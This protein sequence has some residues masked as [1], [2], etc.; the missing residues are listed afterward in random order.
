MVLKIRNRS[1]RAR[2]LSVTG[3][4]EWV[5]GDLRFKTGMH[6]R[7][8]VDVSSGALLALNPYNAE[9]QNRVAFFD[10]DDISRY[11]TADRTE[12]I[13]RNGTLHNPEAMRRLR[14]S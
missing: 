11:F 6:T 12:F 10:T 7:T 9:F 2:K 1:G 5:L 4:M 3:Y 8:E 13:G 14:L